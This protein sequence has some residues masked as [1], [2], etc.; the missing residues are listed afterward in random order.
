MGAFRKTKM[1]IQG[2]DSEFEKY[3]REKL[4]TLRQD[5]TGVSK[6]YRITEKLK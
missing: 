6:P 2:T 5:N 1:R 3:G 4:R